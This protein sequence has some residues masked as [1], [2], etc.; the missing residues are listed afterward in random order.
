M[1]MRSTTFETGLKIYDFIQVNNAGS[2]SN[3]TVRTRGS[4]S[5]CLMNCSKSRDDHPSSPDNELDKVT[6]WY[7]QEVEVWIFY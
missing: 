4:I 7:E 1:I 5:Q 3:E 6:P 2:Q